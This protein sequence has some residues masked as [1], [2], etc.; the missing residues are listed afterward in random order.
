MNKAVE[1]WKPGGRS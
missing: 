1:A